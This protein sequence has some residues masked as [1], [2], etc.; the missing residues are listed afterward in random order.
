VYVVT[1]THLQISSFLML[2]LKVIPHRWRHVHKSRSHCILR[3][4]RHNL[5][6]NRISSP[7][8]ALAQRR[9]SD[10]AWRTL[11]SDTRSDPSGAWAVS[12]AEPS[13]A[14]FLGERR[15]Y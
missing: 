1:K 4:I 11:Y 15:L 2:N 12:N 9:L 5:V 6:S 7:N 3:N 13:K 10:D 8:F 14:A